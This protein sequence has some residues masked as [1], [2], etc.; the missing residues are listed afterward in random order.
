MLTKR[1]KWIRSQ[2]V[3]ISIMQLQI[4][5]ELFHSKEKKNN[6]KCVLLVRFFFFLL[7][8][9]NRLMFCESIFL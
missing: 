7:D 1:L 9:I 5:A 4:L 3:Y 6:L 2:V 8:K